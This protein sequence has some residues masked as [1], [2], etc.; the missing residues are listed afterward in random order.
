MGVLRSSHIMR[1]LEEQAV[2][3][4]RQVLL[5][6]WLLSGYHTQ[7]RYNCWLKSKR[8]RLFGLQDTSISVHVVPRIRRPN[9]P[10][11][12]LLLHYIL[13]NVRR[14]LKLNEICAKSQQF[15]FSLQCLKT[16]VMN[17]SYTVKSIS[18]VIEFNLEFKVQLLP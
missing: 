11:E 12:F 9:F 8:I 2:C 17:P 10:S 7:G 18:W 6:K 4:V 15:G 14:P 13:N 1:C 16:Y 3:F 5:I